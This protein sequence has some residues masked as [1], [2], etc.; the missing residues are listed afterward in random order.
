MI[1]EPPQ[2]LL[3]RPGGEQVGPE[4]VGRPDPPAQQV[5]GEPAPLVLEVGL[6][7]HGRRGVGPAQVVGL[8]ER[9][10]GLHLA[11]SAHRQ[12]GAQALV[13]DHAHEALVGGV[14]R[15]PHAVQAAE[16]RG[17]QRLVD[18]GVG[19]DPG[20][21]PRH[22][23]GVR[24]Q[25]LGKFGVQQAG[26]A[27]AAAVVQQRDDRLPPPGAEA[28]ELPVGPAPVGGV[29]AAGRD[30][31]PQCRV[32]DAARPQAGQQVEVA[33]TFQMPAPFELVEV[34]VADAVE[35]TF[36]PQPQLQRGAV[37][38]R[39]R[40][41]RFGGRTHTD[42]GRRAPPDRP[43][44]PGRAGLPSPLR[45]VGRRNGAVPGVQAG[46]QGRSAVSDPARRLLPMRG[47]PPPQSGPPAPAERH[48]AV[49]S[50]LDERGTG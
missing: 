7:L 15:V 2:V 33:G 10:A 48:S 27:R 4:R 46:G 6:G 19:R 16:A 31:R 11:D 49:K 5:G 21:A 50:P 29:R 20:G 30:L 22:L 17:R 18:R 42:S 14:V 45:G 3:P 36:D 44:D 40:Q 43:A 8:D 12:H 39:R 38:G 32:T 9:R 28:G 26:V 13:E 35:G 1:D 37:P 24:G 41:G 34:G 47:G 23:P 25:L